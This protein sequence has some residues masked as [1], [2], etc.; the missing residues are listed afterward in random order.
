[1]RAGRHRFDLE[2]SLPV[3]ADLAVGLPDH[4][5][6][7]FFSS[8]GSFTWFCTAAAPAHSPPS[9]ARGPPSL[10]ILGSIHLVSLA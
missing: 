9:S 2:I 5:A 3:G 1:M 10:R 7:L 6:V 8:G 4:V